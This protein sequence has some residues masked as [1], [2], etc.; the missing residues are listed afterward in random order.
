M[1]GTRPAGL[2]FRYTKL[3][4]LFCLEH[5]TICLSVQT[6]RGRLVEDASSNPNR[7]PMYK[8][9]GYLGPLYEERFNKQDAA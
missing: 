4:F 3:F 1:R 8:M 7:L 9:L 2:K 5:I 6:Y